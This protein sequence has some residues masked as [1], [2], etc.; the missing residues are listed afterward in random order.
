MQDDI[1]NTPSEA[2]KKIDQGALEAIEALVVETIE[3]QEAHI[4]ESVK[5]ESFSGPLPH[6]KHLKEYK[7]I[8]KS[9]PAKIINMAEKRQDH[10]AWIEKSEVI[11][12]FILSI[13]GW[14]TPTG[15]AAFTLY[16]A[17]IFVSEGKSIESLVSLVTALSVIGGAFYISGRLNKNNNSDAE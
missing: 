13:L 2:Q 17:A 8:D 9:Y 3:K 7:S 11:K 12:D 14:A 15:I 4:I 16:K 5:K 1:Q 10:I 6:P